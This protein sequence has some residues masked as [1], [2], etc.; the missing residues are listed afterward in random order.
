MTGLEGIAPLVLDPPADKPTQPWPLGRLFLG[1]LGFVAFLVLAQH[2]HEDEEWR[3]DLVAG[4]AVLAA[5]GAWALWRARRTILETLTSSRFGAAILSAIAVATALGTFVTQ[6]ATDKDLEQYYGTAAADWIDRLFL[7]ETFHSFWFSGLLAL[8]VLALLLA[9]LRRPFW[10]VGQWGFLLGHGGMIMVVV[11]ASIGSRWGV[12]GMLA[13]HKGQQRDIVSRSEEEGDP[14]GPMRLGFALR[15]DAFE[16]EKYPD[17]LRFCLY[18]TKKEAR[19]E[20]LQT[21]KF[22][23]AKEWTGLRKS[24]LSFRVREHMPPTGESKPARHLITVEGALPFEVQVGQTY[25]VLGTQRSFK[26]VEFFPHFIY[27]IEKKRGVSVDN[28]PKN[29]AL[30][31]EEPGGGKDG[32]A[33]QQWL[34]ANMPGHGKKEGDLPLKYTYPGSVA[35]VTIETRRK[36]EAAASGE[37]RLAAE[38]RGGVCALSPELSLVFENKPGEPRS[39]RSKVSVMENSQAVKEATIAVNAPLSYGGYEFYQSD[40]HKDDLNYSGLKVVRDPGLGVVYAGMIMLSLGVCF[41]FY[42]HPRLKSAARGFSKQ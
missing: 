11:G 9:V 35:S 32:T 24:G 21:V 25:A 4:M 20:L 6:K 34:F 18:Q 23:Q 14:Q 37:V 36:G 1:I 17:E 22:E 38:A 31:V 27:D 33:R 16:V 7:A 19:P 12:H 15:L 41:V 42:V 10:L 39:Y 40:W 5:L 8:L 26:V 30:L 3:A 29:P 28:E 13:L 2:G